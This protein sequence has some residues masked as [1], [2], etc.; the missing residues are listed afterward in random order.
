MVVAFSIM[1]FIP[2]F[3][4][5]GHLGGSKEGSLTHLC[6]LHGNVTT[7]FHPSRKESA[8]IHVFVVDITCRQFVPHM[9]AVHCY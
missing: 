1:A 5:I 4:K 2:D 6:R 8:H 3:V 9:V 7:L